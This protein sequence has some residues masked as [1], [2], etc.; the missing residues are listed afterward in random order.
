M[1]W[2]CRYLKLAESTSLM[3]VHHKSSWYTSACLR[4]TPRRSPD[5]QCRSTTKFA[6][7]TELD[8]I[9]ESDTYAWHVSQ[10]PA[11]SSSYT[12]VLSVTERFDMGR[13]CQPHIQPPSISYVKVE[14]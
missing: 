8:S 7:A 13:A 14:S 12:S 3:P 5:N 4:L 11:S 1:S 2:E 6:A 9:G 10:L